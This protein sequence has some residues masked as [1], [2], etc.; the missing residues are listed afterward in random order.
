MREDVPTSDILTARAVVRGGTITRSTRWLS[1]YNG[2]PVTGLVAH[3]LRHG[4]RLEIYD[5]DA[6]EWVPVH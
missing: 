4:W 5:A 1:A 3:A 2:H 6:R